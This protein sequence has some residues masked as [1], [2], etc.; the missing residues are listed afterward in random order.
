MPVIYCKRTAETD[1]KLFQKY[2]LGKK[3]NILAKFSMNL[4]GDHSQVTELPIMRCGETNTLRQQNSSPTLNFAF[5]RCRLQ[6]RN[7]RR[8]VSKLFYCK[9]GC[10]MHLRHRTFS[11]STQMPLQNTK[12]SNEERKQAR[13]N[14]RCV[15]T[16]IY[17]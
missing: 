12:I 1:R 2:S 6:L 7:L 13:N 4:L 10:W 9:K 16:Y 11:F 5:S 8:V 14:K 15:L 3:T 17:V